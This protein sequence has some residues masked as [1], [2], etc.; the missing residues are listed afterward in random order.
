VG[1]DKSYNEQDCPFADSC[2][3]ATS[4]ETG[5]EDGPVAL[6][7]AGEGGNNAD[8]HDAKADSLTPRPDAE[9]G[10]LPEAGCPP[11]FAA[12]LQGC[13]SLQDPS[14]CGSCDNDCTRLPHLS[15]GGAQCRTG[16]CVYGCAPGY[17]DCADAGSGCTSVLSQSPSCGACGST[18]TA[19]TPNC[20]P[21]DAGTYACTSSCSTQMGMSCGS[22]GGTT[23]C[24]GTCSVP[25]PIN[26][27]VGCGHCGG[28]INCAAAC[29][30]PDPATYGSA[31]GHC[32]GTINCAS[33]C[34]VSDPAN[35]GMPCGACGGQY[36]CNGSCSVTQCIAVTGGV[37]VATQ[38][39]Y[40][41]GVIA[42]AT[43]SNTSL[44]AS[45]L[46]ASI[47]WGDGASSSG[48]P[49]Q[50]GAGSFTISS[51]H[52]YATAGSVTIAVTVSDGTVMGSQ[53]FS[54]TVRPTPTQTE[55]ALSSGVSTSP[56]WITADP[57]T[58]GALWFT[59]QIFS[60]SDST[61]GYFQPVGGNDFDFNTMSV[62]SDGDIA[63]GPDSN[64]WYTQAYMSAFD[65]ASMST[66]GTVV[67]ADT[68]LLTYGSNGLVAGPD[69]KMYVA[70]GTGL[71]Q[72]TTAGT[73]TA[74][75]PSGTPSLGG[76]ATGN[77]PLVWF[78]DTGNTA[79]G[80]FDPTTHAFASY[81][82]PAGS[83]P[84]RMCAGPDGS[85]FWIDDANSA[86]G[87]IN[88]STHA[89]VRWPVPTTS[90]GLEVI[91]PGPDGNLWFSESSAN[92]IARVTPT[93]AFT[94][95][96]VKTAGSGVT[97]ITRG[98]GADANVW[99]TETTVGKIGR[100]SP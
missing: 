54:G 11:G 5:G 50:G 1:L 46:S 97:G 94:E 20:S 42:T 44:P 87:R 22:C 9:G 38:G 25:T 33:A 26:F 23:Q 95:F 66:S 13:V 59:T 8:A 21:D 57:R 78:S 65:V 51:S 34:S 4:G 30:V 76:V 89:I 6:I 49:V 14:T 17:A 62:L 28:T 58:G 31:C 72:V 84:G 79:I 15:D 83:S 90:S 93:G 80:S 53:S 63:Y 96:P 37:V 75:V 36:Q 2:P 81:A 43:D 67:L 82:L 35:Y 45:S 7:D 60:G 32:G 52:T 24:D 77:G 39:L 3:D 98:P 92:Q 18:C 64:V 74:Y 68:S 48:L 41:S 40:L 47:A 99:F 71:T 91:A 12:C 88:P 56:R 19:Q 86:I 69:G 55:F 61:I 85:Y 29:T 100:I 73:V 16:Q 27:G 70:Q 10:S